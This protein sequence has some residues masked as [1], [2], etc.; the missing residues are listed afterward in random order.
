MDDAQ[1]QVAAFLNVIKKIYDF[2]K[3]KGKVYPI[4]LIYFCLLLTELKN[5]RR[6]RQRARYLEENWSWIYPLWYEAIGKDIEENS[7][8]KKPDAS[9]RS[10]SQSSIS[11][12]L[13]KINIFALS[14]QYHVERNLIL[15]KIVHQNPIEDEEN[16]PFRHYAFDGKCRKGIVSSKTGRTEMDITIFDVDTREVLAHK[17]IPDKEGESTAARSILKRIGHRLTYGIFTGDAGYTAPKFIETI[18]KKGHEYLISL[19]GN[20]GEVYNVSAQFNWDT[21]AIIEETFDKDHGREE[22]RRL[23]RIALTRST[24]KNFEKYS[25]CSYL[26]CVESERTEKGVTS[27]EKR[28][29]ISSKGLQG[30]PGK[31]IL[32]IIRE[33]WLQEN[34]LHWV[35]DKILGEDSSAKMSNRS[36]RVLGFL[37][38]IVVSIGYIMYKSVQEFIDRF[39]ANPKKYI[40]RLLGFG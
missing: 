36:S 23:K 29:F 21:V 22:V 15:E 31:N 8:K 17:T 1:L 38:N 10:P 18:V 11:R 27:F 9:N 13:N 33:H 24:A 25:N 35:K 5:C 37:K 39:D 32:R 4:S 3:D 2:R 34:G 12:I 7:N 6:Q 40:R 16:L 14:E 28:Y 26:F 19:K 20:A 30:V